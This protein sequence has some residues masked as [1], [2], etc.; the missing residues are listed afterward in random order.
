MFRLHDINF[1][2]G[3]H[4]EPEF[5]Y[6]IGSF[7]YYWDVGRNQVSILKDD[8]VANNQHIILSLFDM[9]FV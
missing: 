9:L 1:G 4:S 7:N 6:V 2:E 5:L 8:D 3:V